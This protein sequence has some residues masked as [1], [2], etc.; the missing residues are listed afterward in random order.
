MSK[1]NQDDSVDDL[2]GLE[3][4]GKQGHENT[5]QEPAANTC[6]Y[7]DPESTAVVGTQVGSQGAS[8]HHPLEAEIQDSCPLAEGLP[9]RR[10]PSRNS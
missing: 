1:K 5:N 7:A 6:W 3:L 2:F 8:Q 10:Q 4:E 9:Y